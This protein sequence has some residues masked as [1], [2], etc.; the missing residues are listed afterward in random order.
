MQRT[1]TVTKFNPDEK[2]CDHTAHLSGDQRVSLL[3]DLRRAMSKVTHHEYPRR[4]LRVLTIA[5][6]GEG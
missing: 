5:R 1:I 4:L 3:E 2:A 6:R